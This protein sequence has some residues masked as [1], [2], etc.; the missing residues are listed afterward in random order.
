MSSIEARTGART[1]DGVVPGAMVFYTLDGIEHGHPVAAGLDRWDVVAEAVSH[2]L[3]CEARAEEPPA[4]DTGTRN[5]TLPVTLR[6]RGRTRL[7]AVPV[8]W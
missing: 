4:Y 5:W 3:R 6:R 1:G 8:R 7:L 2:R